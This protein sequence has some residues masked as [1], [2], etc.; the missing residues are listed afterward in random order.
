ME[1]SKVIYERERIARWAKAA[2]IEGSESWGEWYEAIGLERDDHLIAGVIYTNYSGSNICMHVAATTGTLWAK[3][4]F[5]HACF[6]YP[7]CQ[8][9]LNRTTALVP[10]KNEPSMKMTLH[11][12]FRKEGIMRQAL[13]DDDMVVLG[14]LKSEC[15]WL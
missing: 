5:L 1:F 10:A 3:P 12:G 13:D 14:M 7:F 4:F 8:L 15:R 11:L 9:N 6:H 2:R